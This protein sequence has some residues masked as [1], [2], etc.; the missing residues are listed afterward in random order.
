MVTI[1]VC[2]IG[3]MFLSFPENIRRFQFRMLVILIGLSIVQ[4]ALWFILNRDVENDEE[5]GGVERGVKQFSRKVS[6]ISFAFRILL[7]IVLWKISLDF[8][9]VVK[10]KNVDGDGMSLE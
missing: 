2:A 4:D 3:F 9:R 1:T 5:D 7:A 10:N 6:Y 8:V